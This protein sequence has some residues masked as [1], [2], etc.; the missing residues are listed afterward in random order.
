MATLMKFL[1]LSLIVLSLISGPTVNSKDTGDDTQKTDETGE[2]VLVA[3]KK[4][5][6]LSS[7]NETP[8][9]DNGSTNENDRDTD[10][11]GLLAGTIQGEIFSDD[12]GAIGEINGI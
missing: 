12:L 3:S 11:L 10:M 6:D 8:N 5:D 2:T 1:F 4:A 9:P 7:E